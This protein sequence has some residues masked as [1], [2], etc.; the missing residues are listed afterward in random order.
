MFRFVRLIRAALDRPA[1]EMALLDLLLAF[2]GRH[3]PCGS[4]VFTANHERTV[5][6]LAPFS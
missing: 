3:S 6:K 1:G 5:P 4:P 2:G